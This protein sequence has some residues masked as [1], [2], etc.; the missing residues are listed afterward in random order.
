MEKD[1]NLCKWR[2]ECDPNKWDES[3]YDENGEPVEECFEWD[4]RYP[5]EIYGDE[6][7]PYKY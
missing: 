1:C 4:G 3:M 6:Y 5:E 7:E 2:K